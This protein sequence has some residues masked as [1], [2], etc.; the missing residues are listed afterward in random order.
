MYQMWV[1]K[2]AHYRASGQEVRADANDAL[3]KLVND[4]RQTAAERLGMAPAAV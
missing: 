2:Q 1:R 3:H 4:W